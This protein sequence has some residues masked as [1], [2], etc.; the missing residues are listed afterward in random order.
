MVGR[1]VHNPQDHA[2]A[3][4]GNSVLN[5]AAAQV[6]RG[7]QVLACGFSDPLPTGRGTWRGV[8]IITKHRWGWAAS[9]SQLRR[10]GSIANIY[11][12]FEVLAY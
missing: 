5:I 11:R 2:L 3:G 9:L 10:L 7:H 6:A 8:N 12:N 4:I 1:L